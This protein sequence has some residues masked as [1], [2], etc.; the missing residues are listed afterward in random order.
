MKLLIKNIIGYSF[1]DYD[2]NMEIVIDQSTPACSTIKTLISKD[3]CYY[4]SINYRCTCGGHYAFISFIYYDINITHPITEE[5]Y[6]KFHHVDNFCVH[7]SYQKTSEKSASLIVDVEKIVHSNKKY[8]VIKEIELVVQ[9]NS[10]S[11]LKLCIIYFA[12]LIYSS[13][14]YIMVKSTYRPGKLLFLVDM[15]NVVNKDIFKLLST[16]LDLIRKQID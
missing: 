11:L 1:N 2:Q 8:D 6:T 15:V 12:K 10:K 4:N 7:Q 9:C 13:E 3:L 16:K 5:L 14:Q